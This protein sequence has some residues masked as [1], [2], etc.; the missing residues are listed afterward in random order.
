MIQNSSLLRILKT[1]EENVN[2]L[3]EK[4]LTANER[5]LISHE[6]KI[7]DLENELLDIKNSILNEEEKITQ[8]KTEISLSSTDQSAAN[9]KF[10]QLSCLFYSTRLGLQINK[11]SPFSLEFIF[12]HITPLDHEHK[13]TIFLNESNNYEVR[14]CTP[15]LS[16]LSTSLTQ[17]NSSN[18]IKKFVIFI[19]KSFKDLYN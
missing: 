16:N 11:L 18:N 10:Y 15:L 7:R 3:I 2:N 5:I 14:E 6:Q 1:V 9:S 13:I 4:N 12:F 17:L 19:R 8:L